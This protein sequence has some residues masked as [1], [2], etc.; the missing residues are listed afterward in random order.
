MRT[1]FYTIADKN[2]LVYAKMLRNSLRKFHPDIEFRSYG[3]EYIKNINIDPNKFYYLATP[4]V[5]HDLFKEGFEQIIKIDADSIVTGSLKHILENPF[6]DVGVVYNW[7]RIDPKTY[8]EI[9]LLTIMPREYFNNGFVVMRNKEFVNDWLNSCGTQHFDRMPMRE[10]GFLNL[11]C[12]YGGRYKVNILDG[13]NWHGMS[14][15]GE[16]H[17]CIMKDGQMILP[18]GKDH[19]PDEDKV[20]KVIHWA[21]GTGGVKM[22]YKVYFNEECI[23]YLDSLV[24]EDHGEK[25]REKQT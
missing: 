11:I 18:K 17:R 12:H 21:G 3:E 24:R 16:W 9:S 13:K 19:Y 22:N 2:N 23:K 4:L 7:N 20:I 15:K 25:P 5:G 6:Y 14:S 1:I 10:Q 8:G